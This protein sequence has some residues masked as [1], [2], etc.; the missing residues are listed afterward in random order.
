MAEWFRL[1][2]KHHRH[3]QTPRRE[4]PTSSHGHAGV[5]AVFKSNLAAGAKTASSR[6]KCGSESGT[7][8]LWAAQSF[9]VTTILDLE[10]C[11]EVFVEYAGLAP[12]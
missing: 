11:G 1:F 6:R 9:G 10:V 3:A 7:A 4:R 8:T 12:P 5:L 2:P